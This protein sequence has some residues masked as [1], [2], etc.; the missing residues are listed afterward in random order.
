MRPPPPDQRIAFTKI[1]VISAMKAN[2]ATRTSAS[3]QD[4]AG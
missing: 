1:H 3:G 4:V 2:S